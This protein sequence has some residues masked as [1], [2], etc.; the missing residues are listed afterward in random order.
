MSTQSHPICPICDGG[1]LIPQIGG[2]V[3]TLPDGEK[4]TAPGIAFAVCDRCGEQAI[5]LA[6]SRKVETFVGEYLELL[7]P[8]EIRAIRELLGADQSEMSEA[9]GLG[10]KTYHRWERG[11]QTPSRSMGYYLRIL[12]KHP[13]VFAWLRDRS[14]RHRDN[15]VT[16]N[17]RE[18]FPALQEQAS[19]YSVRT[20]NPARALCLGLP[21]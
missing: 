20:F 6:E 11:N 17:F 4:L 14:W 10:T 9:L 12:K 13:E 19:T 7:S 21:H 3:T 5:S 16:V 2:F 18:A 8:A 15:V 1:H